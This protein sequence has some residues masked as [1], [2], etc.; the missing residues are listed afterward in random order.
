MSVSEYLK[1]LA[2]AD[3]GLDFTEQAGS[4]QRR[5]YASA[6]ERYQAQLQRGKDSREATRR[7]LAELEARRA[8]DAKAKAD[9]AKAKNA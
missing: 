9:A 8:A 1:R 2:C 5:K 6:E 4:T 3:L 7:A